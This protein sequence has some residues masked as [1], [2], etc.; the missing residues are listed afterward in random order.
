MPA[1]THAPRNAGQAQRTQRTECVRVAPGMHS[2]VFL[3]AACVMMAGL[4]CSTEVKHLATETTDDNI[5]GP[6]PRIRS[7]PPG[8]WRLVD[9]IELTQTILWVSHVLI[10]HE[11]SGGTQVCIGP[12]GWYA[13]PPPPKRTREEALVIAKQLA[14]A[15]RRAPEN[16]ET[17]ARQAS[18]DTV[19]RDSGG[20]LGG[21][22]ASELVR[23]P[24]ILDALAALKVGD[25]SQ[26]IETHCG[27]HIL[28]R[29]V[30]PLDN[31]VSGSRIVIGH[32]GAPWLRRFGARRAIPSRSREQAL[33]YAN[34]IYT[35]A[36]AMPD[37]FEDLVR[38]YSEHRDA[39][40]D[41][42]IGQWSTHEYSALA[43]EIEILAQLG[44]REVAPPMEG[45][46]GFAILQRKANRPRESYSIDALQ[47]YFDAE[48]PDDSSSSRAN[49]N[50]LI[51]NALETLAGDP[52][53]WNRLHDEIGSETP[54]TWKE[55]RAPGQLEALVGAMRP[56]EIAN[57]AVEWNSSL[58]IAR[59]VE[60]SNLPGSQLRNY[61]L[62][63]ADHL[64]ADYL[65]G[66][67]PCKLAWQLLQ[68]AI[69][70]IASP[71]SVASK[72]NLTIQKAERSKAVTSR[73][74]CAKL[75]SETRHELRENIGPESSAR[76]DEAFSVHLADAV[77]SSGEAR[78]L[79]RVR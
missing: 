41:G 13:F 75:V 68:T 5:S 70:D 58:V 7:Y 48:A 23:T 38:A 57:V 2:R 30:V 8:R 72:I 61:E 34:E 25:V 26:V 22:A 35:R 9:P 45:L 69:S 47:V 28:R 17:V 50:N 66:R 59:R 1:T 15:L 33:S 42:Q 18:E 74:M 55:G 11:A 10:R 29:R 60:A 4:A 46:F 3:V 51:G 53:S 31:D 32:D 62:P 14:E 63:A 49:A 76:L 65:A 52:S 19:T 12:P 67:V 36:L 44:D 71:D 43:R 40:D 37:Q 54:I 64:D 56:G 78:A 73:G 16:F 6:L 39:L 21:I 27:F 77:L 79:E 20:S 24:E